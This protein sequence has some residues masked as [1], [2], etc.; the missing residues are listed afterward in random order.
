MKTEANARAASESGSFYQRTVNAIAG[1][2]DGAILRVAF[3]ALLAGTASVLYVDYRELTANEGAA[4]VMPPRPIL[5]PFDPAG[6]GDSHAPNVTTSPEVLEHPREIVM[7]PG[8]DLHLNG[9][10]T[11]GSRARAEE[12]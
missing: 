9:S 3:F 8:G 1:I 12:R 2:E 10:I 4:L 7:A 6:P 5:P 11:P